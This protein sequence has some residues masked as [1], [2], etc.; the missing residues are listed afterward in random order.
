MNKWILALLALALLLAAC[1]GGGEEQEEPAP[2]A[3]R[4]GDAAA[5]ERL[6]KQATIGSLSGCS[7]CHSLEH[8]KT[9]VGPSLAEVATHADEHAQA[10]SLSV[11]EY[12]RQS[13]LDPNAFVVEGFAPGNMPAGF[14]DAL[15]EKQLNDLVAFLL[16][17]K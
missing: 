7:V 8:G 10:M 5:G 17:L 3:E 2:V 4:A 9:I 16:T 13:I 11:E 1:G 15:S 12:L 14:G 6:F